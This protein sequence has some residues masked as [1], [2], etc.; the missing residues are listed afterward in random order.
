MWAG[1]VV[2]T[3]RG[4]VGLFD[5]LAR[6]AGIE[7]GI[8]RLSYEQTLGSA[9]PSAYTLWSSAAIDFVFLVG[10]LLFGRAAALTGRAPARAAVR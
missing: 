7:E 10:G 2:L 3:A 8:T 6:M 9:H 4:G 5:G 1:A